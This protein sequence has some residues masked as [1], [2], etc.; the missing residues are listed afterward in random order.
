MSAGAW[1]ET[2]VI[3]ADVPRAVAELKQQDG[4]DIFVVG[5]SCLAQTLID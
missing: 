2:T 3:S 4:K 1:R 5:S